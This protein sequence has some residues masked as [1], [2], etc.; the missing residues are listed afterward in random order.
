MTAGPRARGSADPDKIQNI[1]QAGAPTTI[2]DAQSLMQAGTYKAKYG[3]NHKEKKPYE[4]ET[5]PL[6]KLHIKDGG[7]T[8]DKE[9]ESRL[10][11]PLRIMNWR[12]RAGGR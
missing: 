7:F 1:V 10:L 4:E 2:E 5:S 8:G 3:F 12:Q 6:R 9:T 11:T